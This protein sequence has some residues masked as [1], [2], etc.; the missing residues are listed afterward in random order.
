MKKKD[1][2]IKN[3]KQ[4]TEEYPKVKGSIIWNIKKKVVEISLS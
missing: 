2:Q 1:R 4:T 3:G